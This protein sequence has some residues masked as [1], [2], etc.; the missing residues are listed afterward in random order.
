MCKIVKSATFTKLIKDVD[1]NLHIEPVNISY[2]ML[3][4][5]L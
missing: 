2:H 3:V 1:I 5:Y 4:K